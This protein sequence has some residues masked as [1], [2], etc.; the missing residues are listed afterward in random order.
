M[1]EIQIDLAQVMSYISGL[2]RQINEIES[3]IK[4]MS[5]TQTQS[6]QTAEVREEVLEVKA[7]V[8][9][10]VAGDSENKKLL[11]SLGE[12]IQ[13]PNEHPIDTSVISESLQRVIGDE[14]GELQDYIQ[15]ILEENGQINIPQVQ[16]EERH[17]LAAELLPQI[18]ALIEADSAADMP[19]PS[20]AEVRADASGI[21]QHI[22]QMQQNA[23]LLQANAQ[24]AVEKMRQESA[25]RPRGFLAPTIPDAHVVPS[26]VTDQL[27][28]L[29]QASQYEELVNGIA[30]LE[31][32]IDNILLTAKE[33][34]NL[35]TG[36]LAGQVGTA[37]VKTE[38]SSDGLANSSYSSTP[39]SDSTSSY[40]YS[41][42]NGIGVGQS[43]I[44][45]NEDSSDSSSDEWEQDNGHFSTEQSPGTDSSN[46][47]T[48]DAG[49]GILG[50]D[51]DGLSD[52]DLATEDEENKFAGSG[53]TPSSTF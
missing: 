18:E 22:V 9:G 24:R 36:H 46:E 30:Y 33:V 12:T 44:F 2:S 14:F 11:K 19:E 16:R 4:E 17:K 41:P 20:I 31:A 40:E 15:Q 29:T 5:S 1:E 23:Q 21:K 34:R 25:S 48:S 35:I 53:A 42:E 51:D 37:S 45:T 28:S 47:D 39:Y 38:A 6:T 8:R 26:D 7:I 27:S 13:E 50:F 49:Y 3:S 52:E 32:R 43:G 10:I